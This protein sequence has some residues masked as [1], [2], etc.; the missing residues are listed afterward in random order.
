ME[1]KENIV[2]ARAKAERGERLSLED[3]LALY[4]DNDILFLAACA[5]KAKEKKS[6]RKV[7]YT[8]NRHINLT[9]ICS[10]NCPLCAFQVEAGDKR[11]FTLES[12]DIA[13]IVAE[14]QQVRN[15][16]EIHIVSALH[17]D[18]PFAYYV[19]VVRQV[20]AALPEADVKAFTPVEIVNF[21]KLTGK[22]IREVLEILQAAGLDSLPGGGAEILADRVRQII[23]P[24]KATAAEWIETMKTAHSLGIRTNASI[25]YGHVETIEERLQ[26]LI[27]IRDIQEETGGF[28]AFMLF[29]FHPGNTKLGEEYDLRRV[30]S[31]EDLKMLAL[32]RLILDNI[33]HIKAFWIMLT[34][35]IAQLALGFGADDLDGTIGEEKI[36][37]AAGAKTNTGITREMLEKMIRET[38]YE[39][40][41]RDTFYQEVKA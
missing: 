5:R 17:P 24:K 11:G 3:A 18:K 16:S 10:A 33:D 29:P 12:E 40:V 30:G 37:H 36:I 32:A 38:G 15:L 25:M 7:F 22:S 31:W 8:V 21:A 14:A 20:K 41:E 4:E 23:C 2:A 19:D 35:P 9:N 28:Q 6:G 26:H 39:P 27:T 34:M 1:L 13:R